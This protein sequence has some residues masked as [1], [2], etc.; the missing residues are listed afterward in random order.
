MLTC[1]NLL[2]LSRNLKRVQHFLLTLLLIHL[3]YH[4]NIGAAGQQKNIQQQN[5]MNTQQQIQLQRNQIHLQPQQKQN[6]MLMSM[7]SD[8][9]AANSSAMNAYNQTGQSVANAKPKTQRK[10]KNDGTKSPGSA[11]GRSPKRKMS[12]DDISRDSSTPLN[13]LMESI[14]ENHGYPNRPSSNA[15]TPGCDVNFSNSPRSLESLLTGPRSDPGIS[16]NNVQNFN[17]DIVNYQFV[18]SANRSSFSGPPPGPGPGPGQG[19]NLQNFS[20]AGNFDYNNFTAPS[21]SQQN[22][23]VKRGIKRMKS[24][25]ECNENSPLLTNQ[26]NEDGVNEPQMMIKSLQDL[27]QVNLVDS[28]GNAKM[29]T[30]SAAK[31][32]RSGVKSPS[33]SV[34]GRRCVGG[35]D[36]VGFKRIGGNGFAGTLDGVNS[37]TLKKERKRRRADS[38]D[39]IKAMANASNILMPPPMITSTGELTSGNNTSATAYSFVDLSPNSNA[40]QLP[41]ITLNMKP[42]INNGAVNGPSLKARKS[43]MASPKAKLVDRSLNRSPKG[44]LTKGDSVDNNGN[45]QSI[46]PKSS[47]KL[48]L[49]KANKI[50]RADSSSSLKANKTQ[51]FR[52]ASSPISSANTGMTITKSSVNLPPSPPVSSSSSSSISSTPSST[53]AL[54]SPNSNNPRSLIAQKKRQA[55]LSAVIDKLN[56]ANNSTI[57]DGSPPIEIINIPGMICLLH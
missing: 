6:A 38:V 3:F 8:V 31:S 24:A 49:Q 28:N 32:P 22:N 4:P 46:S 48:G 10:R 19:M 57:G 45:V 43:G 30:P 14:S 16:H 9:P 35:V 18:N 36:G 40:S 41:P 51:N 47:T 21:P 53:N 39:S 29:F 44:L 25:E 1:R 17:A 5:R 20:D 11:S 37:L 27:R 23:K 50:S 15:S 26:V 34:D 54:K 7:L 52:L 2:L 13:D 42:I 33:G 56:R 12:E 55:S